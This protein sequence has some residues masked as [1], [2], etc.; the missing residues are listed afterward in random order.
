M[1]GK[2]CPDSGR[3]TV[4]AILE[5][6]NETLQDTYLGMP[7]EISRS[8][9]SSFKFLFERMWKGLM[10][11]TD[12]LMSRVGKEAM[13]KFVTQSIPN[14]VMSLFRIPVGMCDSMRMCIA[15]HWW[16]FE[17][18]KNKMHWRSWDWLSAPKYLVDW[19]SKILCSSTKLC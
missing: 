1:F 16:G 5:V 13:L 6:D 4:K 18:G 7:I 19:A 9:T 14:F 3:S 8:V 10:S 2:R 11:W 17:N 12:R 15:N